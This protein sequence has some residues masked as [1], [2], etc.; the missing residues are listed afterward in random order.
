LEWHSEVEELSRHESQE[1]HRQVPGDVL[2]VLGAVDL[3]LIA[4]LLS[5]VYKTESVSRISIK[6]Q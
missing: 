6:L 2:K 4:Q 5:N 1:G 3:K